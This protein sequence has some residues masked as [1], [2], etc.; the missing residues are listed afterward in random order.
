ML[1]VNGEPAACV[2]PRDRGLQ[3]GDGVFETI[4]VRGGKPELWD[5]HLERLMAG[6]R[7][8]D[9]PSPDPEQL[10][11]EVAQ[12][13][14]D[15]IRCVA[16]LVITR[17]AGGRGYRKPDEPKPTRLVMRSPFPDYPSDW[18]DSGVVV[19]LCRTPLGLNPALAGL[20]HLNRL[21]QVMARNEWQNPEIAEG[22]MRDS[23]G[24]VVEG[25]MSNLFLV[26]RGTLVTPRLDR[27]GVAGVMRNRVLELAKSLGIPARE[28]RVTLATLQQAEGAFLTNSLLRMWPIRILKGQDCPRA[29][30]TATLKSALD[31][32]LEG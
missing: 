19:R 6:C 13:T 25:T 17:G 3:Y 5:A 1:L 29:T 28:E 8:L 16:K 12:V 9:I 7:V 15:E 30:I 22:L 26:D 14:A 11:Q 10:A 27:C 23:E 21:E 2:D 32:V 31:R 4:T 24:F 18:S 20:K